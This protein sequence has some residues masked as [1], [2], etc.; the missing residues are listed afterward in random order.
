[1]AMLMAY[2]AMKPVGF[3]GKYAQLLMTATGYIT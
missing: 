2:I 3:N 1:M